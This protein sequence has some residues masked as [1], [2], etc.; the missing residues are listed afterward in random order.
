[1]IAMSLFPLLIGACLTSL[2]GGQRESDRGG[3]MADLVRRADRAMSTLT[4]E[5]ERSGFATAGGVDFPFFVDGAALDDAPE[6]H[7]H[8][9]ANVAA[10]AA[11]T[12]REVVF[13]LPQDANDDGWP[14]LTPSMQNVAWDPT[15][16]SYVLLP[17]PDGSNELVRREDG[18]N[19]RV[20]ARGVRR[21]LVEDAASTGFAFPI[22]TLRITLELEDSGVGDARQE[23]TSTRLVTLPN[24]TPDED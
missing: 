24:G 16:V 17:S 4:F 14:D 1:M 19:D 3:R 5:L 2:D 15:E 13:L 9:A 11:N 21:F 22:D 18:A 8:A 7:R 23:L 6:L 12:A 10:G 20:L